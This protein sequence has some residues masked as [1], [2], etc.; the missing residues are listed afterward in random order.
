MTTEAMEGLT[1]EA[2]AISVD[3]ESAINDNVGVLGRLQQSQVLCWEERVDSA[4]DDGDPSEITREL[5]MIS[6]E[7]NAL[8]AE[9]CGEAV[10]GDQANPVALLATHVS[11][12]ATLLAIICDRLAER[13]EAA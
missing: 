3:R 8:T 5:G 6:A 10:P 11:H 2:K 12:I 4:L 9:L 1:T 13:S 7:M